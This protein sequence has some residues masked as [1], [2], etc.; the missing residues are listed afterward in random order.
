M[1]ELA[2]KEIENAFV[3]DCEIQ[4]KGVSYSLDTVLYLK[5]RYKLEVNPGL[6]IGDDLIPGFHHW[7]RVDE[8][9]TEA[10]IIVLHRGSV[11]QLDFPYPHRYLSN[12]MVPL[13]SS[14]VRMKISN[15]LPVDRDL[16]ARVLSYIKE[17]NL[18][19]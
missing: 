17:R 18:Y 15:N 13:S 14:D 10:D 8:L 3:S 16:P 2:A 5:K 4:R 9:V 1:A 12:T 19:V 11:E 6:I 7:H